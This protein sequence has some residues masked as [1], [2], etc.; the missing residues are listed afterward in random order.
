M[1]SRIRDITCLIVFILFSCTEKQKSELNNPSFLP[2]A[3]GENNELLIVMVY[4]NLNLSL[5]SY[6]LN[7]E[8]L[9][10]S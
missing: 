3:S 1:K 9:I 10:A 7:L 5:I 8:S 4:L 2:N 6:I